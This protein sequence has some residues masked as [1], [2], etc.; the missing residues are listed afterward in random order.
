MLVV[1]IKAGWDGQRVRLEGDKFEMPKSAKGSWFV[2][3]EASPKAKAKPAEPE[4]Q[5]AEDLV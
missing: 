5:P 2:P 3:V 1:A 4:A